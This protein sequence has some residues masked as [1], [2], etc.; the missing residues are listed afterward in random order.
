MRLKG[1]MESVFL[2][3]NVQFHGPADSVEQSGEHIF[4]EVQALV[5]NPP[6]NWYQIASLSNS[7]HEFLSL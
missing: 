6:Y 3:P 7:G 4:Q 1:A 5:C 2:V